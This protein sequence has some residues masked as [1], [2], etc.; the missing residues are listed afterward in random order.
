VAPTEEGLNIWGFFFNVIHFFDKI[1]WKTL[2]DG[3]LQ[4]RGPLYTSLEYF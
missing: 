1:N 4:Q 2:T 3:L